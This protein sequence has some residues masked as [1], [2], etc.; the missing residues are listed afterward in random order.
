MKAKITDQ[1]TEIFLTK[2]EV[3]E[4]CKPGEGANTCVW[5][6]CE[7]NGFECAC[8]CRPAALVDRWI[9]GETNAKR[10]GCDKVNNY[11]PFPIEGY[12][13]GIEVEI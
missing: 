2:E 5:L 12:Y 13:S 4:Y 7:I 8:K 9:K 1:K 10:N 11:N 6:M 3:M